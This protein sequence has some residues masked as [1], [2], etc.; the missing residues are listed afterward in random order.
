MP[1]VLAHLVEAQTTCLTLRVSARGAER[2][3]IVVA[4][5]DDGAIELGDSARIRGADE[6]VQG[7]RGGAIPACEMLDE[8]AHS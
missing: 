8:R 2:R 7:Q 1:Q 5:D 3:E 6:G 4:I